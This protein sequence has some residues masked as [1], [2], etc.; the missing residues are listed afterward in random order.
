MYLC[1]DYYSIRSFYLISKIRI[2]LQNM[3]LSKYCLY[4]E[5]N[6]ECIYLKR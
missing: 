6:D 2:G 5:W 4:F 3:L 1:A